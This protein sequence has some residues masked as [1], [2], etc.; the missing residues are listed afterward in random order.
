MQI[1]EFGSEI[2]KLKLHWSFQCRFQVFGSEIQKLKLQWR[3]PLQI[4]GSEAEIQKPKLQWRAPLQ[5]SASEAEIQKLKSQ[6]GAPLQIS[7]FGSEIQKL[8]LHWSFQCRFQVFESEIQKLKLHW[9][10]DFGYISQT[11]GISPRVVRWSRCPPAN[12]LS[13]LYSVMLF[14]MRAAAT[15]RTSIR[16]RLSVCVTRIEGVPTPHE[17]FDHYDITPA[18]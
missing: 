17:G 7:G 16:P 4:A 8:K 3:A 13:C 5:M 10:F 12:A 6:R 11:Y 14:T 2:Q 18:F 9:G 15:V 1:S